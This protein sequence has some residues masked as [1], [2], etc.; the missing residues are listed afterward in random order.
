[1]RWKRRLPERQNGTSW[2]QWVTVVSLALVVLLLV[3]TH[4]QNDL[5]TDLPSPEDPYDPTV[6]E[7]LL[8][9]SYMSLSLADPE[10][11]LAQLE[12]LEAYCHLTGHQPP[13]EMEELYQEALD[14]WLLFTVRER[15]V[16]PAGVEKFQ[17]N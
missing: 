4:L 15:D 7:T 17:K 11:C 16:P 6:V 1:M 10:A 9:E 14:E 12:E 13:T 5:D 8:D 2:G 3:F